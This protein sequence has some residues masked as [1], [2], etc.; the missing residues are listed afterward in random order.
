MINNERSDPFKIARHALVNHDLGCGCKLV[1]RGMCNNL[2]SDW[3]ENVE[4][5][6]LTVFKST[7]SCNLRK[8]GL[9]FNKNIF[10]ILPFLQGENHSMAHI[11][12]HDK[13]ILTY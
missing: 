8:S 13:N 7:S 4:M 1:P 11:M 6:L 9:E 12:S 5:R 10:S 2:K 3:I